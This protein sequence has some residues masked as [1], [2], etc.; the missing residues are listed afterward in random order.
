M[1]RKRDAHRG[2]DDR[3][4]GEAMFSGSVADGLMRGG[5]G[6]YL[7]VIGNRRRGVIGRTRTGDVPSTVARRAGCPVAVIPLDGPAAV[8]TDG[9][10]LA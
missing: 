9:D 1:T 4:A 2:H 6:A 7:L 10:R 3:G 8:P 5:V